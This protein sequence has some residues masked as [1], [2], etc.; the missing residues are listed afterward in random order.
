M[1]YDFNIKIKFNRRHLQLSLTRRSS[2]TARNELSSSWATFTSPWYI[3]FSTESSSLYFTP[4]RYSSGCWWGF[5]RNIW[6]KKGLHAE[7]MTWN[8]EEKTSVQLYFHGQ[9]CRMLPY[10]LFKAK[11]TIFAQCFSYQVGNIIFLCG[12]GSLDPG[13]LSIFHSGFSLRFFLFPIY[14][15]LYIR[16]KI[17]LL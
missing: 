6:R 16:S 11:I 4:F 1:K 9:S 7:R 14:R 12:T 13:L 3:K 15:V 5:R 2:A 10:R 8:E 17:C